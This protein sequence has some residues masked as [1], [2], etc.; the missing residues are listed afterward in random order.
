MR[1][2]PVI[3]AVCLCCAACKKKE[4]A[5]SQHHD[6]RKVGEVDPNYPHIPM[7]G[8]VMNSETDEVRKL[9]AQGI[10]LNERAPED[11]STPM[12]NA[13]ETD[14]WPVVEILI[15]H[16]ADIWAHDKFGVVA[17]GY[18]LT[19][20][21]LRGS[22]EDQARLRVIEKLR[23][24]GFPLPPPDPDQILALDKAGKWPPPGAQR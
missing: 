14:Q 15:D 9:A 6:D 2:L 10:G 20:L 12:I 8:A 5:V 19:S 22:N 16:G 23:A 13:A 17:G 11:R 18:A 24:R 21:V 7:I 1:V 4:H 3:L